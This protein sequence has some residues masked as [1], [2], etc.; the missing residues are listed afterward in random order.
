MANFSRRLTKDRLAALLMANLQA[1][2]RAFAP[3]SSGPGALCAK[4][5]EVLC[6]SIAPG[7]FITLFYG[8]IDS[9]FKL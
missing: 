7:K 9:G 8:V 5:N 1:A 6:A 4:L 2:V 3:I